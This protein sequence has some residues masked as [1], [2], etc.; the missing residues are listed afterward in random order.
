[1]IDW[2]DVAPAVAFAVVAGALA[3]FVGGKPALAVLLGVGYIVFAAF[4]A[5]A[6]VGFVGLDGIIGFGASLLSTAIL[7]VPLW[8]YTIASDRTPV[9]EEE[10]SA[11]VGE[12]R[13]ILAQDPSAQNDHDLFDQASY[14]R[15]HLDHILWR[16]PA[17]APQRAQIVEVRDRLAVW[18][19]A[20]P[21]DAESRG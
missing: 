21:T 4:I 2:F 20:S 18:A 3:R 9:T 5:A 11:T 12:A 1:M 16:L 19:T 6:G 8:L 10:I 17:D 14:V 13:A 7:V 15:G